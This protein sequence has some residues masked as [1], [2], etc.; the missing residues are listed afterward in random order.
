MNP[1]SPSDSPAAMRLHWSGLTDRGK[2]RAN[3]EDAFLGLAIGR[4]GFQ[5]L[6]KIGEAGF[7]HN[8]FVFAVS[9][10]MGGAQSGEFASRIAI[11]KIT[12]LLPRA[13]RTGAAG[14]D[15]GYADLLQELYHQTH[16]AIEHLGESYEECRGMGA[17]MTMG[18]FTPGWLYFAHIGD[19]RLYYFPAEG[20]MRQL[21][22]D[23]T[24]VGWLFRQGRI[25]EREMRSHPLRN[26][27]QKALGA[28]HQFVDPQVGAVAYQPGDLFL[29]CTDGVTDG[30]WDK[31]LTPLLREPTEAERALPPARRIVEAA[32]EKAGRDNTTAVVIEV[33]E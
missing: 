1:H 19:S 10:G 26:S 8:D 17:T 5:Y 27:I 32:I 22:H 4:E 13:F 24:H 9:D 15:A 14:L 31:H 25:N 29:L 16:R 7:E 28:G 23:D 11:E 20:G 2:V 30:L 3:N 33:S 21:T 6:G 18:W 12:R